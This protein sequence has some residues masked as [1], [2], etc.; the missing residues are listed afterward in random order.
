MAAAT[1]PTTPSVPTP[2]V[3]AAPEDNRELLH[4]PPADAVA[5]GLSIKNGES[6][7]QALDKL[8]KAGYYIGTTP[9]SKHKRELAQQASAQKGIRP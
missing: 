6:V 7:Q 2:A 3:R 9:E 8:A 4:V 5:A 1:I